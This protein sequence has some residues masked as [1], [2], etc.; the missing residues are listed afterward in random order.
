M[1]KQKRFYIDIMFTNTYGSENN[2]KKMC[3]FNN[4]KCRRLPK[5]TG[6]RGISA[7]DTVYRIYGDYSMDEILKG[8]RVFIEHIGLPIHNTNFPNIDNLMQFR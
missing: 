3:K 7:P 1:K 2:F 8:Y 5:D 4:W 6:L